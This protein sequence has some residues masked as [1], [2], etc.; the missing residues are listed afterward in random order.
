VEVALSVQFEP[1]AA[2]RTAQL[3]ILWNRF[4]D[5]Y[6]RIEEHA[7]LEPAREEFGVRVPPQV[8]VRIET[9][10]TPPVPR[11][12]FLNEPGTELIQIQPD[13][14]IHNWRKVGE[15]DAYPRFGRIS[16]TFR[17]KLGLFEQFLAEEKLGRLV[18]DQC[19][20]TYVNHIVAGKGW[21]SHGQ[22]D[23]IIT[24]WKHAYSDRFLKE[25]ES[26]NLVLR[27]LIPDREGKL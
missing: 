21:D 23:Q 27:Y 1:L 20:V 16:E 22:L 10:D 9:F 26:A 13:R 24:I 17:A 14:F 25:P 3:G 5:S 12:W 11:L 8:G 4:R 6:P 15:G 18:P 2:L 7:P 19:E